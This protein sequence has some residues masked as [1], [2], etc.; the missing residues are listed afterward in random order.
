M[1]IRFEDGTEIFESSFAATQTLL[2]KDLAWIEMVHG[3]AVALLDGGPQASRPEALIAAEAA[4]D[5]RGKNET[6]RQNRRTRDGMNLQIC[7]CS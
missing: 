3:R 1:L 6:A 4:S 5:H 7:P 2:A